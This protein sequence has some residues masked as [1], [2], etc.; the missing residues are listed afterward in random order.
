MNTADSAA[1][2]HQDVEVVSK[3][4]LSKLENVDYTQAI[5]QLNM[6]TFV[7]QAAQQSYARISG[8]SLFNSL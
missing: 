2:L 4:L 1:S 8:L 5:S 6:Q 7:L 3:D